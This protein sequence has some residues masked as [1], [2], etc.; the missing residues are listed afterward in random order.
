MPVVRYY[1]SPGLSSG[2]STAKLEII[3]EIS[4]N[5]KGLDTESCF[6]IEIQSK[7]TNEEIEKLKWILG[8]PHS[9]NLLQDTTFLDSKNGEIIEIGPR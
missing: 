2:A 6:N 9:P 4:P 5:V 7:F 3:K 1:K 8:S